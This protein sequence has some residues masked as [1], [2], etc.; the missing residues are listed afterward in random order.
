ME[1]HPRLVEHRGFATGLRRVF[2]GR[3]MEARGPFLRN[4]GGTLLGLPA[5]PS[6]KDL[7]VTSFGS[8]NVGDLV[9]PT[10]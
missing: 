6:R 8:V 7:G 3:L 9:V 10:V 1:F 2:V 4:L 5:I